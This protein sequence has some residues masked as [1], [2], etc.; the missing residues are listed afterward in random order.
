MATNTGIQPGSS[1][2]QVIDHVWIWVSNQINTGHVNNIRLP[3]N[4]KPIIGQQGLEILA[5]RFR[6]AQISISTFSIITKLTIYRAMIQAPVSVLEDPAA[7]VI[8]MFPTRNPK[9]RATVGEAP[10]PQASDGKK[11]KIPRPP[12]AFILYRQAHH[13]VIK[14]QYPEM[15]NNQICE[16]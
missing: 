15:H 8:R 10:E 12:N 13:P 1:V 11:K 16:S 5:D 14:A 7:G 6:Y 3:I 9:G 4:F 2:P